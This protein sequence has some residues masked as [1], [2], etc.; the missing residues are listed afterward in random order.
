M[1]SHKEI[2]FTSLSLLESRHYIRLVELALLSPAFLQL[3]SMPKLYQ[4]TPA[5]FSGVGTAS[6]TTESEA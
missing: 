5:D 3:L 6:E 1:A 4:T 2:Y